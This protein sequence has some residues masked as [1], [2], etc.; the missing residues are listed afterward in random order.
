ME[1]V[2]AWNGPDHLAAELDGVMP[3]REVYPSKDRR[4]VRVD[5]PNSGFGG[6]AND[7]GVPHSA[8]AALDLKGQQS[9]APPSELRP[10]AQPRS[11]LSARCAPGR[12]PL[13]QPLHREVATTA[14]LGR[15]GCPPGQ[16]LTSLADFLASS[17]APGTPGA[18]GLAQM[19]TGVSKYREQLVREQIDN[20]LGYGL[21]LTGCLKEEKPRQKEPASRKGQDVDRWKRTEKMLEKREREL[22]EKCPAMRNLDD[23]KKEAEEVEESRAGGLEPEGALSGPGG[24]R[25]GAPE[26][27]SAAAAERLAEGLDAERRKKR[28]RTEAPAGAAAPLARSPLLGEPAAEAHGA[29]KLRS[30]L[31]AYQDARDKGREALGDMLQA[32]QANRHMELRKRVVFGNSRNTTASSSPQ[33]NQRI[34]KQ[35]RWYSELLVRMQTE[36]DNVPNVAHFILDTV[37]VV[38]DRGEEF[39]GDRFF[40]MLANIENFEITRV[41]ASLLLHMTNGIEDVTR[42]D[43]VSWFEQRRGDV[44]KH[45]RDLLENLGHAGAQAG[46]VFDEKQEL[47]NSVREG[48]SCGTSG[49]VPFVRGT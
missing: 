15:L 32:R 6:P 11:P 10:S 43:L 5:G 46:A 45:I 27:P 21:N 12:L 47:T 2:D 17:G 38:L 36:K 25:A 4:V 26:K 40:T 28:E 13:G 20:L 44:P 30:A 48:R 14:A 33:G 18:S 7:G 31:H 41:V 1:K 42:Q 22:F 29:A 8:R 24:E 19:D 35:L 34:Q 39:R 23:R 49:G 3:S 9:P 37:R 16:Q